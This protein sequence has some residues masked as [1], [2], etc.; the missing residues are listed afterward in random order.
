MDAADSEKVSEKAKKG[1]TTIRIPRFGNHFLEIQTME[2]I[3]DEKAAK[4]FGIEEGQIT[5]MIHSGSR[6]CGHQICADY[7]QNHG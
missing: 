6:G 5:V 3:F 4:V 2:E 1:G 7:L